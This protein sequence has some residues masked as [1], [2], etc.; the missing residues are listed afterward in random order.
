MMSYNN[1]FSYCIGRRAGYQ[2]PHPP[3]ALQAEDENY[4]SGPGTPSSLYDRG[5]RGKRRMKGTNSDSIDDNE[6]DWNSKMK[7]YD[8]E[9]SNFSSWLPVDEA[10]T[11]TPDHNARRKTVNRDRRETEQ[12]LTANKRTLKIEDMTEFKSYDEMEDL[13][14]KYGSAD[15]IKQMPQGRGMVKCYISYETSLDALKALEQKAEI[16]EQLGSQIVVNIVSENERIEAFSG[17]EPYIVNKHQKETTEIKE[18]RERLKRETIPKYF[19]VR[20][21]PDVRKRFIDANKWLYKKI[22]QSNWKK[23][24]GGILIEAEIDQSHILRQLKRETIEN[25]PFITIEPHKKFNTTWGEIFSWE[26]DEYTDQELLDICPEE[27]ISVIRPSD[28]KPLFFLEFNKMNLMNTKDIRI[29]NL[30]IPLRLKKPQPMICKKCLIYGHTE[31]WCR[32]SQRR[33][34]NCGEADTPHSSDE[35][36]KEAN[37]YH[38]G[39][40]HNTMSRNCP[41]YLQEQLLLEMMQLQKID[42]REARKINRKNNTYASA[43]KNSTKE[44]NRRNENGEPMLLENPSMAN[45]NKTQRD[46]ITPDVRPEETKR[47]TNTNKETKIQDQISPKMM[48]RNITFSERGTKQDCAASNVDGH[49]QEG[50]LRTSTPVAEVHMPPT[51]SNK[52]EARKTT[53][54]YINEE[55]PISIENQYTILTEAAI[56]SDDELNESEVTKELPED[57]SY[58]L[59][60]TPK[61]N[62]KKNQKSKQAKDKTESEIRCHQ[63]KTDYKTEQCKT[64]HDKNCHNNQNVWIN[65]S[66]FKC[67]YRE[68][69]HRCNK[70][71]TKL[72]CITLYQYRSK[73]GKNLY[74][75][76]RDIKYNDVKTFRLGITNQ[77]N[78]ITEDDIAILGGRR[79]FCQE[80]YNYEF[81]TDKCLKLHVEFFHNQLP[82]EKGTRPFDHRCYLESIHVQM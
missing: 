81:S 21:K 73:K 79:I 32:T 26:L 3:V 39:N 17:R 64:T 15:K 7:T 25:S 29:E 65:S 35:C 59:K 57:M 62:R 31:R 58:K 33:C 54:K 28:R 22:G 63:C 10:T 66:R 47:S 43:A 30:N 72:N 61:P 45:S 68:K 71:G 8:Y 78:T 44:D 42:M 56:T 34:R 70:S 19:F 75:D 6:N 1:D 55:Y 41:K 52:N 24:N 4:V 20:F 23:Y 2:G 14:C 16:E 18:K 9:E 37:C 36:D 53:T 74:I 60:K 48:T 38:C 76:S 80:C 5:R 50:R 46:K 27:V 11:R 82:F 40:P 12:K 49:V 67:E 13:A 77:K 69:E 51:E